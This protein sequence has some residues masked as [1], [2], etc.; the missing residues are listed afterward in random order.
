MR[1]LTDPQINEIKRLIV[2]LERKS[3]PRTIAYVEKIL[4]II[5][6]AEQVTFKF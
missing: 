5:L 1:L 3:D 6:Q 4:T 2:E